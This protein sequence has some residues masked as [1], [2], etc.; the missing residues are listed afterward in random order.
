MIV[1][2]HAKINLGLHITGKLGEQSK[3]YAGYHS[4]ETVLYPIGIHDALEVVKSK[5]SETRLFLSGY[6]L[7]NDGKPNLCLKVIDVISDYISDT[8]PPLDVYLHKRI[9]AGAGLGGGS[10]NATQMLLVLN[11]MLEL[12]LDENELFNLA[13]KLGSDCP[14]FLYNYPMLATGRGEV[15]KKVSIPCLEQMYVLVVIPPFH[16]STE[17]AYKQMVPE[18]PPCSLQEVLNENI[19]TWKHKLTNQFQPIVSKRHP[20]I[21]I[22]TDK[23]TDMGASY[24]S[25]SGSGSAVFGIFSHQPNVDE[26][27]DLFPK[28]IL[29]IVKAG[30]F[31]KS[32]N[33]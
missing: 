27:R 5:H 25:M 19:G 1:F 29:K 16:V 7:L 3:E 9:P 10:S 28:A 24:A 33:L 26:L 18:P 21:K 20:D 11:R 23:M 14:F 22:I 12:N 13:A 8:L 17:W 30:V 6:T 31:E 4:I 2:P 32:L 15:L